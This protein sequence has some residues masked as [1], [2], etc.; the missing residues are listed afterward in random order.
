M[1][2]C[3]LS[4]LAAL[5]IGM[6]AAAASLGAEA[7]ALETGTPPGPNRPDE[8]FRQ[9]FSMEAAVRFLDTAA[10]NWQQERKCFACHSDYAFFIARPLISWKVP[11][12]AQLRS[13]LEYLAE[14][15]RD[16]KYYV[17]EGVMV[18]SVL[19]QN[20]ALTT[21]KLHPVTRRALDR[22]WTL[23][24][25][26]GGFDWMK[27]NQPPSE[28]DDHYGAT[29]AAIGAGVAPD[30][31]RD[32]PAAR[33]G[34][35][36]IRHYFRNHPPTQLHHRAMKLL[37]SL[38][39]EGILTHAERQQVVTDLFALQKADGGWGVGTMGD[40]E[41]SDGKPRDTQSSDGYGTG[42]AVHVLRQAGVPASDPRIQQGIA[43]L[44][45]HQRASGRWFTRS[46]WKDSQHFISHDGTAYAIRALAE[47]GE[48]GSSGELE[49][50]PRD[51]MPRGP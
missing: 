47:C 40:W 20:D 43:W 14:H 6:A 33:A 19:A 5:A 28:V 23:Q 9:T 8:P 41:R 16:V 21:G 11:A 34:L 12:H 22:M 7:L 29:V 39:V 27:Y 18:A 26:D 51:G 15:P 50:G 46:M 35:E 3:G 30:Q 37:A 42:F 17:T 44:K 32:M 4:G 45:T 24:R 36:K 38:H 10:L 2:R 1:G 48:R 31:Y 13:K 25:A 49:A